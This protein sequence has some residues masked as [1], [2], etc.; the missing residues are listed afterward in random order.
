MD[1]EIRRSARRKRNVTARRE[2]GRIVVLMPAHLSPEEERRHVAALVA[3]LEAR[4]RRM[5]LSDDDLLARAHR[6]SAR[7]LDGEAVPT[8]VRWVGN[9]DKRWGSCTV[10]E[11]SIRLSDRMIGM[12]DWVVDAVLVHELAHLLEPNH[13]PGFKALVERYPHHLK[14]EGF[15][16]GV[17]W[18]R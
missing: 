6:L 11:G 9:Q 18:Q 14:A 12:P 15:L 8:S 13:G 5:Q 17:A 3:K 2:D 1:V 16:R 7:Y 10:L 4:E